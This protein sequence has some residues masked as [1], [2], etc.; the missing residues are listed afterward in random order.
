MYINNIDVKIE[1]LK[2]RIH[3]FSSGVKKIT[4]HQILKHINHRFNALIIKVFSVWM[5]VK[6]KV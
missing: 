1:E 5:C 4:I 6:Y 3:Q 2:R